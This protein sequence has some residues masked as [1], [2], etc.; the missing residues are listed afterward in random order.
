LRS[1]IRASPY[2]ASIPIDI[3][4]KGIADPA[5]TIEAI[6]LAIELVKIREGN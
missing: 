1:Q 2:Q 5:S 4:G 3:A 6:A